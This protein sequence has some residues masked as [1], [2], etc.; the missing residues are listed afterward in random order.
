MTQ[1]QPAA[2]VADRS[3]VRSYGEQSIPQELRGKVTYHYLIRDVADQPFE[4]TL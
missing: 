2:F 1:A 3:S 4:L